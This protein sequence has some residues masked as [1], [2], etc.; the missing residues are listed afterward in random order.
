LESIILRF[1]LIENIV[2]DSGS[3]FMTIIIKD[4]TQALDMS[5]EYHTPWHTPS[6]GNVE[7][8]NQILKRQITKLILETKLPWTKCLPVALLQIRT[9]PRKDIGLSPYEILYGLPYL[10][11]SSDI[12]TMETKDQFLK[13]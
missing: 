2:S 8:M 12:P 10:G 11:R 1:G 9:A 4:L 13:N 7:R 5:W 3:H 6:S